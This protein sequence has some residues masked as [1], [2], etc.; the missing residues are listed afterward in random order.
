MLAEQRRQKIIELIRENGN[1]RVS[2]LSETFGVTEPTI[3]QD[4]MKLE[5]DGEIV[6]DH[7]GAFLKDFSKGVRE[8]SLHHLDNM[9]K[10][11]PIGR[12]AAEFVE[13]GDSIILD[14]GSTITEAAKHLVSRKN[15]KVI[16]NSLN[17][18]LLMGQEPSHEIHMTGGEFKRQPSRLPAKK[19]PSSF[20]TPM[21]TSCFWPPPGW[22]LKPG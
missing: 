9:D 2:Y 4:L 14:S 17:I 10:K 18:T 20:P 6:R 22:L 13:D 12:K 7:G 16:T 5:S 11:I 19:P 8:L 21:S 1:A 3:R 15:L